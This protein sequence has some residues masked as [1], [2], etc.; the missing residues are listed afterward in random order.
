MALSCCYSHLL[1]C[2]PLASKEG[3]TSILFGE[4][5]RLKAQICQR[6]KHSQAVRAVMTQGVVLIYLHRNIFIER[7]SITLTEIV[8]QGF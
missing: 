1:Y 6:L 2:S 5:L 4:V 8:S 3:E 7:V